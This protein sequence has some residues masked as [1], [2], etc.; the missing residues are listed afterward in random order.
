MSRLSS[1]ALVQSIASHMEAFADQIAAALRRGESAVT[2][3]GTFWAKTYPG[4]EGRNPRT[5]AVVPVPDKKLPMLA[6]DPDFVPAALGENGLGPDELHAALGGSDDDD[7]DGDDD[8]D[9]P[10][11][12]PT[13]TP[14][15]NLV[16]IAGPARDAAAALLAAGKPAKF[17]ALGQLVRRKVT[18]GPCRGRTYV[19]FLP[20]QILKNR[21]NGIDVD[22]DGL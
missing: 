3:L 1:V 8:G 5:G 7:D 18:A 13:T 15:T 9:D 17:P 4:Y 11:A 20:S 22:T 2:P 6:L 10:D 21:L 14:T 12:Y 16:T 19:E